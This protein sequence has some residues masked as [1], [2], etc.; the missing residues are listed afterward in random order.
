MRSVHQKLAA[1]HGAAVGA[2]AERLRA[3]MRLHAR[4]TAGAAVRVQCRAQRTST[5]MSRS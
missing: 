5:T 3:C 4:H 1:M 2:A